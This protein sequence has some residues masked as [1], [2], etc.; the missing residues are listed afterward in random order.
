MK[1]NR[2][3]KMG[4]ALMITFGEFPFNVESNK[5]SHHDFDVFNIKIRK[6]QSIP[7]FLEFRVEKS[8]NHTIT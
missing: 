5:P 2:S 1:K 3:I 7:T 4:N 8:Y 6:N